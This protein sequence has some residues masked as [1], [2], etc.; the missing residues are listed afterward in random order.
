MFGLFLVLVAMLA[1]AWLS[2]R[3]RLRR[4]VSGGGPQ[5]ENRGGEGEPAGGG[6]LEGHRVSRFGWLAGWPHNRV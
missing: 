4:G 1:A 5:S 6:G 3:S 2:R